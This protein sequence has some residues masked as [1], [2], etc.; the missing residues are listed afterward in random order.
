MPQRTQLVGNYNFNE[1]LMVTEANKAKAVVVSG[2]GAKT[3]GGG[4]AND[5][6]LEALFVLRA[7]SAGTI[8]IGGFNDDTGAAQ[9][10]V[11]PVGTPAA[12]Y[13]FGSGI[14][15][16]AGALTVNL[17]SASDADLVVIVYKPN[18]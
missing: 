4:V 8:T 6:I 5:A 13:K 17:S 12:E 14:I 16:E 1:D 9:D 2:T 11:F 18:A 10:M 3:I 7:T 15:N